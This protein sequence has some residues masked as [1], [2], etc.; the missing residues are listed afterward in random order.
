MSTFIV[1]DIIKMDKSL[2]NLNKISKGQR[3]IFHS[4]MI[5]ILIKE[6]ESGFT[7]WHSG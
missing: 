3:N 2:G 6:T 4:L 1:I 5:L 7:W